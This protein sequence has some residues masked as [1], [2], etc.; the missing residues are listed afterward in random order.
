V[1]SRAHRIVRKELLRFE[2]SSQHPTIEVLM[3]G[4]TES[5]INERVQVFWAAL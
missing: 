4:F 2:R 1:R 3:A 5:M